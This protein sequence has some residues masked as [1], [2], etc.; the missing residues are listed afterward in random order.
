MKDK[1]K[2]LAITLQVNSKDLE[3]LIASIFNEIVKDC[4][5][6]YYL[7][8]SNEEQKEIVSAYTQNIR[9]KFEAFSVAYRNNEQKR[10]SFNNLVYE[11][12]IRGVNE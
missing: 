9:D 4:L 6:E 1:M 5:G 12:H 8:A 2:A 3:C 11:K 7:N 10:L